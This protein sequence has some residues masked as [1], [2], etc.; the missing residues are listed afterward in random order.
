MIQRW[1]LIFNRSELSNILAAYLSLTLPTTFCPMRFQFLYTLRRLILPHLL[2]E[3][4]KLP[5]H[6]NYRLLR[7]DG[8]RDKREGERDAYARMRKRRCEQLTQGT[9]RSCSWI[10]KMII[11]W[12]SWYSIILRHIVRTALSIVMS[13]LSR[14]LLFLIPGHFPLIPFP[15]SRTPYSTPPPRRPPGHASAS[16]SG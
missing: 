1:V 2:L 8:R 10:S 13:L 14:L 15:S 11:L 12:P 6:K 3:V 9:T 5:H 4:E 16:D 7:M